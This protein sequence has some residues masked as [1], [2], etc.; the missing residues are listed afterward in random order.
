MA[1]EAKHRIEPKLGPHTLFPTTDN[2]YLE[3]M[4]SLAFLTLVLAC[5]SYGDTLEQRAATGALGGAAVGTVL[6]GPL[7]GTAAGAAVGA[8]SQR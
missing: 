8:A 4:R 7:V 1:E 3:V 5:A 6:G 2:D